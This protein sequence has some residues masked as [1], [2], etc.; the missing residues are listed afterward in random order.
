[1]P[2]VE[3]NK[4]LLKA[5]ARLGR[6]YARTPSEMLFRAVVHWRIDEAATQMLLSADDTDDVEESAARR[7]Y[8]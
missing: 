3:T 6:L 4:G 2:F 8:W 7:V 1:M 5:A